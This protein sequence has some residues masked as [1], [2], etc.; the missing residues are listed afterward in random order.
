MIL[1]Y[2]LWC[3]FLWRVRGGAWATLLALQASG[4]IARLA[5]AAWF[6]IPLAIGLR[7]PWLLSLAPAIFAGITL[8]GWGDQMDIGRTGGTRWGDAAA[9]S[10]WGVVVTLPSA[11]VIACL[12]GTAW[13][14]LVAG[15]LFGPVYALMWAAS[16][17]PN[18]LNVSKLP[19]VP[20]FAWGPT[21]WAEF[22]VGMAFGPAILLALRR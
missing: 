15:L 6:A 13:P 18:P 21:E 17:L 7:Q 20:G 19:R 11:V 2:A 10:G 14:V 5:V 3:G 16:D 8:A 22:V 4:T 9:M 1:L 12:G